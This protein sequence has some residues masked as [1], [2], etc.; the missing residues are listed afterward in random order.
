M[1]NRPVAVF[2]IRLRSS[3]AMSSNRSR[4][5]GGMPSCLRM[6]R[7]VMDVPFDTLVYRALVCRK[8]VNYA[9]SLFGEQAN[10][11]TESTGC[12]MFLKEHMH[13]CTHFL[14]ESPSF[15]DFPDHIASSCG[16]STR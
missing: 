8:N 10:V 2:G 9:R 13:G 15:L 6:K 1:K 5:P 12:W 14:G 16:H 4:L 11:V 7:Q 3:H